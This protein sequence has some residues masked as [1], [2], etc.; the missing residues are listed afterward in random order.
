MSEYDN[1]NTA[2]LFPNDKTGRSESFPD[3][4]GKLNLNGHEFWMSAWKNTSAKGTQYRSLKIRF[5]DAAPGDPEYS[6]RLFSHTP[7]EGA[8]HTHEGFIELENEQK[9]GLE[10]WE[11]TASDGRNLISM[12]LVPY[13]ERSAA[14]KQKP[15]INV[16]I[17]APKAAAAKPA[18]Q[19]PGA[20]DFDDDD[21]PF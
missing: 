10:G 8:S 20:G 12:R 14:P 21:C 15:A 9:V 17:N 2:A 19:M 4:G 1:T 16:S 7:A 18:P 6:G 13:V 11:K 3:E 5:K